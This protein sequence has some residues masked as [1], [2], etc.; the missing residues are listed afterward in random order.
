VQAKS[1]MIKAEL[2]RVLVL[3]EGHSINTRE[4]LSNNG[5]GRRQMK[6]GDDGETQ[7]GTKMSAVAASFFA[8]DRLYHHGMLRM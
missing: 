6:I 3:L 2:W 1:K 8:A 4:Q 5:G 7:D